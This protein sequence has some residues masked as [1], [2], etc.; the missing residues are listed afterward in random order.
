[1]NAAALSGGVC[2]GLCDGDHIG[3]GLWEHDA[4]VEVY[5]GIALNS[6]RIGASVFAYGNAP[7]SC[8]TDADCASTADDVERY[9]E[10]PRDGN[11]CRSTLNCASGHRFIARSV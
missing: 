1:M 9:C 5:S 3:V 2:G 8:S 7:T 6:A 10:A 4:A 11:G